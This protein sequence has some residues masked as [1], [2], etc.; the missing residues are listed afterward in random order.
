MTLTDGRFIGHIIYKQGGEIRIGI[1]VSGVAADKLGR[2]CA[3]CYMSFISGILLFVFTQIA[4]PISLFVLSALDG[5]I[6]GIY[7]HR[8][9]VSLGIPPT[10]WWR[11]RSLELHCLVR[12]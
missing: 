12:S 7:S 2:V 6:G 3:I 10:C 9:C 8:D 5:N 11:V 4:S 1:L